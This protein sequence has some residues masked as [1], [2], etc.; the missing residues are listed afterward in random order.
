MA[1]RLRHDQLY[2]IV[3]KGGID[4]FAHAKFDKYD[5]EDIPLDQELFLVDVDFIEEYENSMLRFFEGAA[6]EEIGYVSFV[7]A[8]KINES[9]I[10]L[11]W[12]PN[13]SDRFHEVSINLPRDQFIACVGSRG[14]DEKPRVFVKGEWLDNIYQRSYSIFALIDAIDV[15]KAL[16]SGRITREKL[17]E[18]RSGID[19]ISE[20]Y[21][22]ISFISFADS[23][24]LKSN[25]SVGHFEN[26]VKY[27]YV[28]EVFISLAIDINAL[29]LA[30]LGLST[31]AIITQGGNEYYDDTLLH[32]SKSKKHISL[33]SLGIPFA[34]LMEIEKTVREAIKADEHPPAELYLDSQ[35]YRSLNYKTKF[36]TNAVRH[37]TYQSKVIGKQCEYYYSTVHDIFTN[38]ESVIP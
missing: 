32:I 22:D 14:Y 12:Y 33:N 17:I 13:T 8:R 9:S 5:F 7:A 36:K 6:Y 24:L 19:S 18:L 27:N 29:Y 23:L 3:F 4:L 11:S 16:E 21:P 28:P 30:T 20:K 31:Y 34:Q 35:Y 2:A 26:T 38:L 10:K 1:Y 15:L 37:H 25:W